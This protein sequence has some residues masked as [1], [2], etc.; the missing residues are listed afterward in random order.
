[1]PLASDFIAVAVANMTCQVGISSFVSYRVAMRSHDAMMKSINGP[2]VASP[3][4][5]LA[6]RGPWEPISFMLIQFINWIHHLGL[7]LMTLMT[8]NYKVR[9]DDDSTHPDCFC[10]SVGI[11]TRMAERHKKR[12]PMVLQHAFA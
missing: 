6:A 2:S 9:V 5:S 3:V 1:M 12:A 4:H 11:F 7:E 8:I 10:F